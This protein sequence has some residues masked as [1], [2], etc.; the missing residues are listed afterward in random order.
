MYF[1]VYENQNILKIFKILH[2]YTI[3]LL[4][5]NK[6]IICRKIMNS[7]HFKILLFAFLKMPN[8]HHKERN[9][10]VLYNIVYSR[11]R[12]VSSDKINKCFAFSAAIFV[13]SALHPVL[14]SLEIISTKLALFKWFFYRFP[15]PLLKYVI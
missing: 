5:Q 15:D 2:F 1:S 12:K 3:D 13:N 8:C 4:Y 10:T 11:V 9:T 14:Q 7:D 6:N